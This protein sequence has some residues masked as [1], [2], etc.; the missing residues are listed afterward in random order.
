MVDEIVTE[1]SVS[2]GVV[3]DAKGQEALKR[4]VV[5]LRTAFPDIHFTVVD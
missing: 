5:A 3:G 2:H 1:D 4:Y